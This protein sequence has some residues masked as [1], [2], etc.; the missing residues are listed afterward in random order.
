MRVL[1]VLAVVG[2][3]VP[4]RVTIPRGELSRISDRGEVVLIERGRPTTITVD[5]L[6]IP[7][8]SDDL[9]VGFTSWGRRTFGGCDAGQL[10]DLVTRAERDSS[11]RT[12][13]VQFR[14]TTGRQIATGALGGV[15]GA[16]IGVLGSYLALRCEQMPEDDSDRCDGHDILAPLAAMAFGALVGSVGYLGGSWIARDRY[17]LR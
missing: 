17:E 7:T 15:I 2:C 8:R 10:D 14:K 5:C 9:S 3:D 4:H 6:R 13:E 11:W 12:A 1:L 16:G